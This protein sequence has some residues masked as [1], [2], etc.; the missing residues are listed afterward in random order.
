[1]GSQLVAMR[2]SR[3]LTAALEKSILVSRAGAPKRL[4]EIA[5]A[6]A[7]RHPFSTVLVTLLVLVIIVLAAFFAL[8]WHP[9]IDPIAQPA[10][11]SFG[12][13]L[14]RRG[15]QLAA[16]GDCASCHT[17][18][19]GS[20]YAGGVALQTQFGTLH[21]TNITPE[22]ETGIG[23]WSEDAFRRA[24][25]EGVSRDGHLLYPAFPYDH[26]THLADD[27]IRAL[28][29]FVMT[30]DPVRS[31]TPANRLV[32]PLQFRP[33][34]A[35]W[36]LLYLKQG[37]TQPSTQDA[38]TGRG[39]YL[40]ESLA[41]CSACHSPR[42]AL[43]AERRDEA[44][45]AGGEAEGWHATALNANSPSPVPWTEA[46]LAAYLR[47]GLVPDHALTAGPM[48]DVVYS[49]SHADPADVDA[50][51][52]YVA[53]RMGPLTPERQ[54]RE[55]ASRQKAALDS[56]AAVHPATPVPADSEAALALGASV[57][58]GSC[59]GC[60]DQGRGLSSDAALRLP[61]AVALHLPDPR[62]LIHIIRQGIQPPDGHTGRW[63][64]PFEGSLSDD[65]LTALVTWLRRQGTDAPPWNDVARNVKES[66]TAP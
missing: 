55:T 5:I 60:H 32:F 53:A 18:R 13:A 62:N 31:E 57:Y 36:N 11:A 22:P 46:S 48:Q 59:A 16:L 25:R 37:P 15:E 49:L 27:D 41:H 47:T 21:G 40:V 29:A 63:M 2:P 43:G 14:V 4:R 34:V 28:Y 17:P 24:L 65:E 33:L 26:F 1:M 61:L 9:A 44:F 42:N 7:G 12:R 20:P 50:I 19:A 66:G 10:R 6:S 56:L 45:L 8:A 30:R 35:G 51:A 54:A 52:A 23:A 39:E 58:D 64:P 38:Q 3:R